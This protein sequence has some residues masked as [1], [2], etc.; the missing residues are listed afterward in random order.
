MKKKTYVPPTTEVI[1]M[2][3]F[4]ELCELGIKSSPTRDPNEVGYGALSK[5][6]FND[7]TFED[8]EMVSNPWTDESTKKSKE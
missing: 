7:N 6:D 1:R 3:I 4:G 2:D 5:Q 8:A